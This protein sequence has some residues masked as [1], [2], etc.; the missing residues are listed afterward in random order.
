MAARVGAAEEVLRLS[1]AAETAF[2]DLGYPFPLAVTLLERGE[3]L[4]HRGE[5]GEAALDEAG[6]LFDQL[7][8]APWLQR[9]G[10]A[11]A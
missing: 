10:H 5:D 7:G 9:T 2:R 3:W 1:A 8:A 6:A 4:M 11:R